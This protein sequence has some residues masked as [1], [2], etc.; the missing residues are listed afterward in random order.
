MAGNFTINVVVTGAGGG[1]TGGGT[2]GTGGGAGTGA[3]ATAVAGFAG[4]NLSGLSPR[5]TGQERAAADLMMGAI[6]EIESEPAI[7][8]RTLA[9]AGIDLLQNKT[10]AFPLPGGRT[11]ILS[12]GTGVYPF[13]RNSISSMDTQWDI[14]KIQARTKKTFFSAPNYNAVMDFRKKRKV[15][16]ASGNLTWADIEFD[17]GVIELG[18]LGETSGFTDLVRNHFVP[19]AKRYG[20]LASAIAYKSLASAVNVMQHQSGDSYYNQQLGNAIKLTQYIGAVALGGPLGGFIAAGIVVNELA[21][22]VTGVMNFNFDRK[23]ERTEITNNMIAAGNASYGRM[24]GVG[25]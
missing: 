10:A 15:Y 4:S 6:R 20:A 1:G 13:G 3:L 9:V 16:G 2:G 25:V 11:R 14:G 7:R 22:A 17:T 19:N 24:R 23:I 21:D 18:N 5:L 8:E 12:S